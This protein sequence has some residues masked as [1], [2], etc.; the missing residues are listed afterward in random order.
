MFPTSKYRTFTPGVKIALHLSLREVHKIMTRDWLAKSI[1]I[2]E[3]ANLL[4]SKLTPNLTTLP[5][6]KS[7]IAVE[8]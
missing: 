2:Y 6:I 5:K 3:T 4:I 8:V 1:N 7:K